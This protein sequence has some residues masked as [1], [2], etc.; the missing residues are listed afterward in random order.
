MM[1]D[2]SDLLRSSAPEMKS[3]KWWKIF[4]W[5]WLGCKV[6]I[7]MVSYLWQVRLDLIIFDETKNELFQVEEDGMLTQLLPVC[8]N[9]KISKDGHKLERCSLQENTT[10]LLLWT[11]M[12]MLMMR[13]CAS[14][15]LKLLTTISIFSNPSKQVSCKFGE[16]FLESKLTLFHSIYL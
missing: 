11:W 3:G 5:R 2:I 1:L 15:L 13:T 6:Q 16:W 9:M 8:S 10:L 7:W 4:L 14:S 12:L